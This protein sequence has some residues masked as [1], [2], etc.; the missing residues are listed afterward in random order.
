M[1]CMAA[2]DPIFDRIFGVKAADNLTNVNEHE[3]STEAE[4]GPLAGALVV[5]MFQ[6]PIQQDRSCLD[7]SLPRNAITARDSNP[8]RVASPNQDATN[9]GDMG[10]SA[11]VAN[12]ITSWIDPLE[13][14]CQSLDVH[15]DAD[16]NIFDVSW[17]T[18]TGIADLFRVT[19][20]RVAI[21]KR[22]R[23]IDMTIEVED[24]TVIYLANRFRLPQAQLAR[25]GATHGHPAQIKAMKKMLAQN[26]MRPGFAETLNNAATV[27]TRTLCRLTMLESYIYGVGGKHGNFARR[28]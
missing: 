23:P 13:L 24:A 10:H 2:D 28:S 26:V 22:G 4:P 9:T 19:D 6:S 16:T 12:D 18:D 25:I 3:S 20:E 11:H 14:Q 5:P 8:L 7:Q 15:S 1:L 27:A 17:I 21:I